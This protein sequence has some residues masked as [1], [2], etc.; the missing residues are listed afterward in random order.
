MVEKTRIVSINGESDA[1]TLDV[2]F[3]S[4]AEYFLNMMKL[5]DDHFLIREHKINKCSTAL[6]GSLLMNAGFKQEGSSVSK[7]PYFMC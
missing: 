6:E 7:K 1:I 5:I 3:F 4:N 2:E